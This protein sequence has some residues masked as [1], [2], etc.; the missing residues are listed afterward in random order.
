MQNIFEER[1][2]GWMVGYAAPEE[3]RQMPVR[4]PRD[5]WVPAGDIFF[6]WAHEWVCSRCHHTVYTRRAGP[7]CP[8]S[9]CPSCHWSDERQAR[10]IRPPYIGRHR[11]VDG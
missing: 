4:Q 11:K 2:D 1:T 10:R 9:E 8:L 5:Y 6:G 7:E 3:A